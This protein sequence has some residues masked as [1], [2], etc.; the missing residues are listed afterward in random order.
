M[1]DV[2]GL[3]RDASPSD[4]KKAYHKLAREHHPDKGGD[5]EKF[6]KVQEAYETLIDPEKRENFD[7]F[8]S[9]EGPQQGNFNPND[10][11]AQMFGGAFGGQRGPI[12]RAEHHHDL[13][14]TLEEAYRGIVRNMKVTLTKR[15]FACLQ[16]CQQCRGSGSIH[17]QMGPMA[18][19]QPC[20]A[21]GG[22]GGTASGCQ[23]CNFK[24]KKLEQ[25]NLE[26]KIP[27]GV[28]EGATIV[29]S[30]LGEQ[31]MKPGEEPGDLVFHVKIKSHPDLMRMGRDLVF[32]TKIS[33]EDSVIGKKVAVPH[34]DG[35][36]EVN[37]SEFGVLDPRKDYFIHGKGFAPGGHLR[38]SFDVL[39]PTP[40]VK[41][42]LERAA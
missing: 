19:S 4:I 6:K 1:Y 12:R 25:L 7:R 15:C 31:P 27:K 39:Y 10:L 40:N 34:F 37:T 26:L 30:G 11:F 9:A 13:N 17:V 8:G 24:T 21:C 23:E 14:I 3:T 5:P 20:P 18:F 41:F 16:K 42:T 2:L 36:I 38:L 33:F 32:S 28:D 35:P 29:A 22:Q